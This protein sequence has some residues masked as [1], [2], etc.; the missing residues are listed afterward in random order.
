[1]ALDIRLDF[2]TKICPEAI[3]RMTALRAE[4]IEID[5]KLQQ[6][7]DEMDGDSAGLRSV[8]LARTHLET[9]LQYAI[10]SLCILGE[11]E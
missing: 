8:S 2:I 1:M 6:I 7:S 4:F 11:E 5:K 3:E 10:K 9:G